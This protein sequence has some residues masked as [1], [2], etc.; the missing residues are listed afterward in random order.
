MAFCPKCH[1]DTQVVTTRNAVT[2]RGASDFRERLLRELNSVFGMG[3]VLRKRK[4]LRCRHKF[5]TMEVEINPR[6]NLFKVKEYATPP[7]PAVLNNFIEPDP[8]NRT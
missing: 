5:T 4:C 2:V 3:W 6:V 7:D 8:E 1:G